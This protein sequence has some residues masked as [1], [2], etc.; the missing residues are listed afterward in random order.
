[1]T[2]TEFTQA[3]AVPEA[4]TN[5]DHCPCGWGWAPDDDFL[6]GLEAQGFAGA[7][8]LIERLI[9]QHDGMLE[10]EREINIEQMQHVVAG[11]NFENPAAVY[12]FVKW[13][14]D[15]FQAEEER[16]AQIDRRWREE[17]SGNI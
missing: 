15:R 17:L 11:H 16:E 5:A 8:A 6:I 3:E 9:R 7:W 13:V 4:T 1:M 10:A 12:R 2:T 14:S